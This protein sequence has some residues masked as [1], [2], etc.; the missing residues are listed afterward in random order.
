MNK[1][2]EASQKAWILEGVVIKSRIPMF[3]SESSNCCR[4]F[5][6]NINTSKHTN[7]KQKIIPVYPQLWTNDMIVVA[8]VIAFQNKILMLLF[9]VV[10]TSAFTV[11]LILLNEAEKHYLYIKN[12]EKQH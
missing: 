1:Q 12:N 5:L 9:E 10:S 11:K 3:S 8:Q 6:S 7:L 4:E 2:L